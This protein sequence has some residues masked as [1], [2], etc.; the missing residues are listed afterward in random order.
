MPASILREWGG[1]PATNF[2]LL[3]T[4]KSRNFGKALN[5]ASR[6]SSRPPEITLTYTP[7]PPGRF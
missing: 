6:E 3:V 7:L 5:F 1:D 2:G 4:L